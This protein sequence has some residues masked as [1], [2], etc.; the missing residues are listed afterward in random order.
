MTDSVPIQPLSGV[1]QD[2]AHHLKVRV[3]Y[4][5]TDFS[6]VVYYA[7]YLKFF[8][9]GR[10]DFLRLLGIH[11]HELAGL[12]EPLAF[13]VAHVDVRYKAPTRIDDIVTV[14]SRVTQVK[15]AQFIL[16]QRIERD[17]LLLCHARFDIVCIDLKSKPRR[18]PKHLQ[19]VI[20]IH[21]SERTDI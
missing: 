17:G 20:T 5:D 21:L 4:E 16:D 9:R 13:A 14:V 1:I 18:L 10:S 7:N 2:N 19:D 8:E 3:Y 11:H 6:G 15:A 12:P